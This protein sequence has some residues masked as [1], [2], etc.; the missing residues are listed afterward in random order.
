LDAKVFASPLAFI[1]GEPKI[2]AGEREESS[3]KT[4]TNFVRVSR[5]YIA[6]VILTKYPLPY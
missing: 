2:V 6:V 1:E 3:V 4:G 5:A